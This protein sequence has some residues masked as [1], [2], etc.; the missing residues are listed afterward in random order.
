[1][2]PARTVEEF[3]AERLQYQIPHIKREEEGSDYPEHRRTNPQE[4]KSV[5]LERSSYTL[6]NSR[7]SLSPP[8][9][10]PKRPRSDAIHS[11]S[12]KRA[13][14]SEALNSTATAVSSSPPK[15]S[16]LSTSR[17]AAAY[18]D[19]QSSNVFANQALDATPPPHIP[20]TSSPSFSADE[21]AAAFIWF[22]SRPPPNN[23]FETNRIWNDFA[24]TVRKHY[25]LS[26]V[27]FLK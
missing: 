10:T 26:L 2:A 27:Y 11:S 3:E 18:D 19:L 22:I 20:S 5:K 23:I 16:V 6:N 24:K 21:K 1:M 12:K 15:L 4:K 25:R 13:R 7:S 17:K 14:V 9:D 8:R